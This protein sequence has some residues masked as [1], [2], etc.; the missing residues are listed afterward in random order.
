MADIEIDDDEIRFFDEKA[1][2][3]AVIRAKL[4]DGSMKWVVFVVL[5]IFLGSENLGYLSMP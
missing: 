3:R 4:P 5:A 1:G 2:V